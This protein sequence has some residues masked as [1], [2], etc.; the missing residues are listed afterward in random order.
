MV[1]K[2]ALRDRWSG[3]SRLCQ[4]YEVTLSLA[5][6]R[7]EGRAVGEAGGGAGEASDAVGG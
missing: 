5:C 7:R 1:G 3:L 2:A 6:V 4:G